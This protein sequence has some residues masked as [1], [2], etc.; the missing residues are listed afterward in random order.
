LSFRPT[1]TFYKFSLSGSASV[2]D[3]VAIKGG[4]DNTVQKSDSSD[5]AKMPVIGF[6]ISSGASGVVVQNTGE[7]G[8]SGQSVS[9]GNQY[10][11]SATPG[12]ITTT[13]PSSGILQRV[14]VGKTTDRLLIFIETQAIYL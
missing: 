9:S 12:K 1:G 5:D 10:F 7:I 2:G 13:P 8:I 11:V 3:A 14:G 6:V 4:V